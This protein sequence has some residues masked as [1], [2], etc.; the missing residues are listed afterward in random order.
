MMD[1]KPLPYATV[2]FNP[3]NGRPAGAR[4]DKDG[5][6]VLNFNE[7]RRGAIPGKNKVMITT[8][9]EAAIDEDGN[10]IPASGE[11]VPS[12]YNV[13]S[14]LEF[15]VEKGKHNVADFNLESKGE[16]IQEE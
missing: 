11:K 8:A 2:V 12:Q 7:D 15:V 9:T 5:H 4:T 1:G 13:A 14:T 16:I 3:E 6:Y 10:P